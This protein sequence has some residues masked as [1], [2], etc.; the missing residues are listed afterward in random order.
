MDLIDV[1][2]K[3]LQDTLTFAMEHSNDHASMVVWDEGCALSRHLA[4]AYRAVLP[5]AILLPFDKVSPE[6][7]ISACD[8]LSPKDLVVLIQSSTFRIVNFRTRV[9]LYRRDLK[10]IDH[11]HLAS[12]T[13][14]E[15][16]TYVAAL[17]YD[18][19]YYRSVGRALQHKLDHASFATVESGEG[20]VLAFD[21]GFESSKVNIGDFSGMPNMG[22]QFPLGE[23]FTEASDLTRVSGEVRIFGFTDT[24]FRLNAPDKPIRLTIEEGRVV[25]AVDSTEEFD[26]VLS[27]VRGDE[28]AV[29]VREFGLGMNRGFS[30]EN[31]VSDV[32]SYERVCGIHLSLGAKHNVYKKRDPKNTVTKYHVDVFVVTERVR[33]GAEIVYQ[34]GA[35]VV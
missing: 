15:I 4:E 25:S 2:K 20:A 34:D 24:T 31:R 7:V 9:E 26:R 1:T 14:S 27:I 19:V 12:M 11:P 8:A 5:D 30:R 17:A 32:G 35:W 3:N 28:G 16:P 23:V 22:G 29:W 10:V 18:P 21:S 13:D 33:L 6:A